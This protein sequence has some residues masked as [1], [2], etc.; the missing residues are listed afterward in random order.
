MVT[1]LGFHPPIGYASP[2][3]PFSTERE[4]LLTNPQ[5]GLAYDQVPA[6]P[7]LYRTSSQAHPVNTAGGRSPRPYR[8][9]DLSVKMDLLLRPFQERGWQNARL[10]AAGPIHAR[11]LPATGAARFPNYAVGPPKS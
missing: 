2:L 5:F 8:A 11:C 3:R 9:G 7:W 6:H 10:P 4:C 1:S